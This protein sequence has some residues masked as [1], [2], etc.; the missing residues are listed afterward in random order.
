MW[1][2]DARTSAQR[3]AGNAHADVS[4]AA[5][6]EVSADTPPRRARCCAIGA[7]FAV[8]GMWGEGGSAPPGVTGEPETGQ[9]A[10]KKY[11]SFEAVSCAARSSKNVLPV[12]APDRHRRLQYTQY[13]P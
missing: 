13:L 5:A 9:K 11:S 12:R 8:S 6:G 7:T 1:R 3:L 2:G 4:L 10:P